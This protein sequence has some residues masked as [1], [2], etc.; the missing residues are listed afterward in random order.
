MVAASPL[1]LPHTH[2]SAPVTLRVLRRTLSRSPAE[3]ANLSG[4][5]QSPFKEAVLKALT[6]L[7]PEYQLRLEARRLPLPKPVIDLC[8]LCILYQKL[9]LYYKKSHS[10]PRKESRVTIN[11][12]Y[13]SRNE[14]KIV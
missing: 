1:P 2:A 14:F 8:I 10:R 6:E 7:K 12:E 13:L 9:R 3:I 5:V 4:K 11:V